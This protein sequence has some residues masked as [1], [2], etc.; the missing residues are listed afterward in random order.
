MEL[1]M[2]YDNRP[3][4]VNS[5]YIV[6]LAMLYTTMSLA[7]DVV[8]FKFEY[9]FGFV[10]SGATIIFPF[11]YVLGDV[12]CEVYGWNITMRVVWLALLCESIFALLI[13]AIIY[14]PSYGIGDHQD[15]YINVMGNLW[16]F[17]LAGVISNSVSGLLNI[18]FMSKWKILTK[19]KA[20]WLRSIVSTCIS[21]FV[22]IIITVLI[23]FLPLIKLKMTMK[24]FVDA[25]LLEI[26][27]ALL[28]VIPA[29]YLV[30]FL[31]NK[32]GIDAFDY[33]VSYNPFKLFIDGDKN[34]N[35]YF[36]SDA[37]G[38]RTN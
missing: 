3:L 20:F 28:F 1:S 6:L 19:G 9:F 22:L 16:L 24:V 2:I 33:G 15:Q 30:N 8:A 13:T 37:S 25:Y 18:Y 23:A 29:K 4:R 11:T 10:E 12:M 17:V 14:M 32:E 34:E 7:A 31:R 21:E 5:K 26:V 36:G 27:Y 38:S 35:R